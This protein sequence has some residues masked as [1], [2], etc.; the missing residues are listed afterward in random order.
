ML[1]QTLSLRKYGEAANLTRNNVSLAPCPCCYGYMLKLVRTDLNHEKLNIHYCLSTVC[2]DF[3][4]L[5]GEAFL[6]TSRQS[7][8]I[9][10]QYFSHRYVQFLKP[11]E[12][13]NRSDSVTWQ[14]PLCQ[15]NSGNAKG[16]HELSTK[17]F[18]CTTFANRLRTVSWFNYNHLTCVFFSVYRVHIPARSDK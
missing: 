18:D 8:G 14:K 2:V 11:R 1:Y 4:F 9:S 6:F 13:R 16:K 3:L 12:E 15:Q 7:N 5:L 17:V 10:L